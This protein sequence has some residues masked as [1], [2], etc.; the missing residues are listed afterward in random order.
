MKRGCRQNDRTLADGYSRPGPWEQHSQRPAVATVAAYLTTTRGDQGHHVGGQ[1]V[2]DEW[3]MRHSPSPPA[4]PSHR[5]DCH[6]ADALCP[7][8]SLLKHLTKAEGGAEC[9]RMAVSPPASAA[10]KQRLDPAHKR[11]ERCRPLRL[12]GG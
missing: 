3:T 2:F 1:S 4:P 10:R 5:R 7:A 6:F 9:S 12:A 11:P 8:P